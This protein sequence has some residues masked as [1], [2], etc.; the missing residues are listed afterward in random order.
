MLQIALRIGLLGWCCILLWGGSAQAQVD[1]SEGIKKFTIGRWTILTDLP[2]D[3]E[4]ESWPNLLDQAVS[5][6]C[7]KWSIDSTSAQ[8]WNLTVHCMGDRG[9]FQKAGLLDGVPAF[10][11]GFQM[12]DRVFLVDQP[13]IYYRR[14]LLLHELTHWMMYR[15]FGGGGSPWFMEGMAEV[16]GTHR[17]E[18]GSL[19]L[20]VIPE[21]Q[22][23]VPHWGRFKRLSDSIKKDGVP[24]FKG[25]LYYGN[26]RQDRMDRYCWSWAA[27]VFL[28]HHPLYFSYLEKAFNPPLDYSMKL[29][30][31]FESSL[32]DRWDWLERDWKLFV[33]EFD[34]GYQPSVHLISMEQA[35]QGLSSEPQ[36]EVSMRVDAS[37]SWQLVRNSFRQGHQIH[38]EATGNYVIKVLDQEPWE[39]SAEGITYQYHRHEPMGKLMGAYLSRDIARPLEMIPIGK[40]AQFTA[41][42]DGW[43]FLRINEPIR[44]RRDNSGQLSVRIRVDN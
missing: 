26:D 23:E 7:Q 39:S 1:S 5:S 38:L 31:E 24:R 43:L 34:F 3:R 28:V 27:C 41:P 15:A 33:D 12:A 6:L 4:L 37:Q 22:K 13:S 16:E 11:D 29:S 20:G 30:Q 14:H 9:V 18:N 36:A 2:I 19:T 17:L 42:S 8:S 40:K 10:E 35:T 21:D 44:E 25:I 32:E